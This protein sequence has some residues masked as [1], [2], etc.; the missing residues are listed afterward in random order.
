MQTVGTSEEVLVKNDVAT[1]GYIGIRNNDETN[2]VQ[3]GATTAE[4]SIKLKPGEG[5]VVPWQA[6]NV[7][8]LANVGSCAVEYLLVEA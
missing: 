3:F 5:A 1:I 4:Y 6:T 2:F 8:A 7:Y